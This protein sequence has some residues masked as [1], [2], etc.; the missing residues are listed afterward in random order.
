MK[1]PILSTDTA[2][3]LALYA[4]VGRPTKRAN[5]LFRVTPDRSEKAFPVGVA[6]FLVEA[7]MEAGFNVK[8]LNAEGEI[9]YF[10]RKGQ[11]TWPPDVDAFWRECGK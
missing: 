9:V 1:L 4:W 8:I 5:M 11:V 10:A 6:K 2:G 3:P 7:N